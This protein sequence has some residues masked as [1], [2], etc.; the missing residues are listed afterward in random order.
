MLALVTLAL[1][2]GVVVG[3][4]YLDPGLRDEVLD[5]VRQ[6]EAAVRTRLDAL[7]AG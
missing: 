7:R 1:A 2:A 5:L 3:I 4:L 6:A